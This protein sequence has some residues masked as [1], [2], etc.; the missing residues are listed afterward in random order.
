[1]IEPPVEEEDVTWLPD[2]DSNLW[3]STSY[4]NFFYYAPGWSQIADPTIDVNGNSY[5]ISLPVA[6][7]D[8]WQAQ[9]HFQT[10][11]STSSNTA[12]DFR[13]IF[14]ANQDMKGVTVKLTLNGDEIGR[15]SC[16]ERVYVLV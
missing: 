6:T 5:K 15:A 14:N 9:I 13:C 16:R 8:Q 12:Y 4:T 2:A 11:M 3:K 10:E 7:S 1:M